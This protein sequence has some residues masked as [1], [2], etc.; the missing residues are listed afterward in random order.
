MLPVSTYSITLSC[1]H[2]VKCSCCSSYAVN[3]RD[4]TE[5]VG[6]ET[7]LQ[8]HLLTT[9]AAIV[10]NHS[11]SSSDCSP[12]ASSSSSSEYD[13]AVL[14]VECRAEDRREEERDDASVHSLDQSE[15]PPL[16]DYSSS[17]EDS[18]D[19]SSSSS[20]AYEDYYWEEEDG[21]SLASSVC[22]DYAYEDDDE[23]Y[24]CSEDG[25]NEEDIFVASDGRMFVVNPMEP[26]GNCLPR[27]LHGQDNLEG[28]AE[29]RRRI[30]TQLLENKEYY[31]GIF[32]ADG[33]ESIDFE[34]TVDAIV[35]SGAHLGNLALQVFADCSGDTVEVLVRGQDSNYTRQFTPSS[36]AP[37]SVCATPTGN[38]RHIL[39]NGVNHYDGAD[40]VVEDELNPVVEELVGDDVNNED[41]DGDEEINF[42]NDEGNEDDEDDR[43]SST[44]ASSSQGQE[45]PPVSASS[46]QESPPT[47]V[48]NAP[49]KRKGKTDE[50][51]NDTSLI[52]SLADENVGAIV[53][54]RNIHHDATEEDLI[55]VIS[56]QGLLPQKVN[57][58]MDR[59][60]GKN[61]GFAF[62]TFP[63]FR[64]ATDA[65]NVMDGRVS[66][67]GQLLNVVMS[68]KNCRETTSSATTSSGKL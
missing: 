62:V 42:D 66:L 61:R 46:S 56:D 50:P 30:A 39:Y 26:D 15:V 63:S 49:I 48:L 13:E 34:E 51:T 38:V 35:T 3:S 47:D 5:R 40:P 58:V 33:V 45:S 10:S 65:C 7:A 12:N 31:R 9:D 41:E 11:S 8:N 25:N 52:I 14:H 57:L 23:E 21:F 68:D 2:I 17:S 20:S 44:S 19:T 53:F 64:N 16:E 22:N 6:I 37:E 32:T 28:A 29:I 24:D 60:S 27:A 54:V 43:S 1:P 59:K 67:F 55:R 4:A 36:N 18:E